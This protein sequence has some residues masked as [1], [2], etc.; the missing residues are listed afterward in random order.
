MEQLYVAG[1][2]GGVSF[3]QVL[4]MFGSIEE[5]LGE[6]FKETRFIVNPNATIPFMSDITNE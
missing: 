4:H 3:M 5:V 6:D 2:P 1:G